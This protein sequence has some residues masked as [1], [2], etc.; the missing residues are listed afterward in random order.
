MN[1]LFYSSKKSFKR[2]KSLLFVFAMLSMVIPMFSGVTAFAAEGEDGYLTETFDNGKCAYLYDDA[3]L[4]TPEEEQTLYNQAVGLVQSHDLDV[5]MIT[6]K[7][8]PSD[9]K[10]EDEALKNYAISLYQQCQ[11]DSKGILMLVAYDGGSMRRRWFYPG[12][13]IVDAFTKSGQEYMWSTVKPYFIDLKFYDGY[14]EFLTRADDFLVQYEKGTPYSTANKNI[15]KDPIMYLIMVGVALVFGLFIAFCVVYVHMYK[16]QLK[17]VR[18][19]ETAANYER[20]GSKVLKYQNDFFLYTTV[21]RTERSDNDS[22]SS[23]SG[24]GGS[25]G[26]F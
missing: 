4:F 13:G 6:V 20:Q 22:S 5:A 24:S 9:A 3:D 14:K 1:K 8:L 21:S 17:T 15:P 11:F 26:D 12:E 25:G 18:T 16:G 19:V 23:D 10:E 2:L 7:D